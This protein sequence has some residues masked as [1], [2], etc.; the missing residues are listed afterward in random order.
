[1]GII[2]NIIWLLLGG[3]EA[4]IGYFC[5]SLV[6][7]CTIVGIPAAIQ[8]FKMGMLCLWPFKA[9]IVD[10]DYPPGCVALL[11]NVVWL[12]FPGVILC[13]F[14]LVL[15]ILFLITIIGIPFALQHLKMARLALSPFGKDIILNI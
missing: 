6:L 8:T 7:A 12:I 14:H 10:A 1:M 4:A 9:E 13:L 15:A 3:F 11:L 5:G 2:G